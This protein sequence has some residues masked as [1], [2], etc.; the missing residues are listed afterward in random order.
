MRLGFARGMASFARR[1]RT[2]RVSTV[3]AGVFTPKGS[4]YNLDDVHW[5]GNWNGMGKELSDLNWK[6]LDNRRG[7]TAKPRVSLQTL[8]RIALNPATIQEFL[9]GA[10]HAELFYE[11]DARLLGIKPHYE[12]D[13]DGL[14]SIFRAGQNTKSSVITARSQLERWELVPT[15]TLR[16]EPLWSDQ[17]DMLLIDLD[18]PL[19]EPSKSFESSSDSDDA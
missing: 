9:D 7:L 8:G 3:C 13:D 4:S 1:D 10:T 18:K 11:P 19:N 6:R 5:G 17:Y 2:V 16:F 12:K 15:E 14:F